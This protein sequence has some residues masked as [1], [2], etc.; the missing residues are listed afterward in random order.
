MSAYCRSLLVGHCSSEN[1][2]EHFEH[3]GEDMKWNPSPLLYLGMD[4]PKVNLAFQRQLS[5]SLEEK[6]YASFLDVGTCPLHNVVNAFTNG[7]KFLNFDVEQ[8]IVDIKIDLEEVTELPT[9]FTIKH[10]STCWVSLKKVA[11]RILEQ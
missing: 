10:S 4:G 5:K 11:V 8:F 2:I 3:F 7:M 1:L 9:H 6:S